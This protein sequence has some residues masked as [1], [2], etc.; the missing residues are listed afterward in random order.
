MRLN[1]IFYCFR[2]STDL[3]LALLTCDVVIR[4]GSKTDLQLHSPKCLFIAV[5][6]MHFKIEG[7]KKVES[8]KKVD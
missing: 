1:R 8:W 4:M 3:R 6:F 7:L 2:E 5:R